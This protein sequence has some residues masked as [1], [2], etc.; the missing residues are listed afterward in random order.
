MFSAEGLPSQSCQR[1]AAARSCSKALEI[2]PAQLLLAQR[3]ERKVLRSNSD[4]KNRGWDL[5]GVKVEGPCL[6]APLATVS[7][8]LQ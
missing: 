7:T 1:M 4:S 8:R 2:D 6:E 5:L 3:K